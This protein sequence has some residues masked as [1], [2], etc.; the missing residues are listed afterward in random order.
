[1]KMYLSL[2]LLGFA[3]FSYSQKLS[4]FD[5]VDNIS[6]IQKTSIYSY[7]NKPQ[8][9]KLEDVMYFL[10]REYG[11]DLELTFMK[12]SPVAHYYIFQQTF[13][14]RP[15]HSA[16]I[17]ITLDKK[18]NVKRIDNGLIDISKKEHLSFFN[19][20][21][22]GKIKR[23]ASIL[24]VDEQE[25][26]VRQN[27][28]FRP[29]LEVKVVYDNHDHVQFIFD[30]EGDT[31]I[32]HNL[33]MHLHIE[34][35][36]LAS[37]VVFQ[38]DPMTKAN[39]FWVNGVDYDKND[40]NE[41]FL[42][43]LRDTL[44]IEMLFDTNLNEFRL[45]NDRC[46]MMEF[47]APVQPIVTSSVPFF[48]Y[49]RSHYGF[50]EVNAYYHITNAQKNLV[51]MGFDL[52]D[53]KIE[54]DANALGGQDNSMFSTATNPPR[55]FFGEGGVDD[56]EDADVVI[57]E[58]YHAVS[59]SAN[60]GT[61]FGSE[62]QCLDEAI[63]DYFGCSYSHSIDPF[64][65]EN[66]F[67]WDGHNQYWSGRRGDNPMNKTYPV[68]FANG[69]IYAHTDLYVCALMEIYFAIGRFKTDQLIT[70]S[71]YGYFSNMTFTDAALLVVQADSAYNAGVNV[72]V[73]WRIFYDKGILP[74]NP[75]SIYENNSLDLM[76]LGTQSFALGESLTLVNKVNENLK[77]TVL[78]IN[79]RTAF[80]VNSSTT[81]ELSGADFESGVYLLVAENDDGDIQTEKLIKY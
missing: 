40:M 38:P 7:S 4:Y 9:T 37:V 1:M 64:K 59:N 57:H 33:N 35:D 67:T 30:K 28:K 21:D 34:K 74:S 31:L 15:I 26:I 6:S 51:S 44:E 23:E 70:E 43:P 76:I 3:L 62:R 72:P 60:G 45:E 61:N 53:Y 8:S 54:V 10:V 16:E 78:D 20:I 2:F 13:Q 22:P 68:S 25:I 80:A 46:K 55:L 27:G 65:W 14:N 42:N 48:E 56:A 17:K 12:E 52:V 79:G 47:S 39:V 77:I 69:N 29:A 75:V 73:I 24:S 50:E 5:D 49:S 81:I 19:G 11:I 32:M 41:G 36:T 18:G 71:L 58:Y 66:V 63:G